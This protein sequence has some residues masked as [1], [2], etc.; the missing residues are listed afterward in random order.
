MLQYQFTVSVSISEVE[1]GVW[2]AEGE[3][4][5]LFLEANSR[6]ELVGYVVSS[7]QDLGQWIVES[8]PDEQGLVEYCRSVGLDCQEVEI[9]DGLE[10][11][12]RELHEVMDRASEVLALTQRLP[13]SAGT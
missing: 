9:E 5:T 7:I 12:V 2:R 11:A 3:N 8:K 6:S 4:I 10:L 1:D 13:V